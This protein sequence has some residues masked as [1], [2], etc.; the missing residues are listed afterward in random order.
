TEEVWQKA[1]DALARRRGR[2][3]RIGAKVAN[4]FS[5]LLWDSRTQTRVWIASQN[6]GHGERRRRVQA[7]MSGD[8]MQGR[9]ASVSV[10]HARFEPAV[11]SLLA[12]VKPADVIGS[13]PA[14]ESVAL[15]AEVAGVQQRL[16][17]LEEQ[18]TGDGDVA[19]VARA[20]KKLESRE[21][22]LQK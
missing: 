17:Q 16:R 12:E 20:A 4:L 5:G 19:T 8:A 21:A 7:L 11:L 3:G 9:A 13:G 22:D 1:Q 15:A 6:S 18:L 14:R 2:P 10:P